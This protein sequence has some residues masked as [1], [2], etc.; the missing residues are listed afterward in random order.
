[1][2]IF[3]DVLDTG[4]FSTPRSP[5]P[6]HHVPKHEQTEAR[7]AVRRTVEAAMVVQRMAIPTG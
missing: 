5:S 7:G 4:Q 1:M 2:A 3:A 6:P